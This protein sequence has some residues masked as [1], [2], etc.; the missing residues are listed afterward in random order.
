MPTLR[1]RPKIDRLFYILSTVT[2]LIVFVPMLVCGILEP[3]TLFI[4]V[5]I[6][7]FTAYFLVSPL[8]GYVE[9][10]SDELFIKYGFIMKRE[11]P[12]AK[13]RGIER[14]RSIIS[15]SIMSLKNA[16]EHVNIK[17]NT[18]DVTTVS[19]KDEDDFLAEL[20]ARCNGRLH[21]IE[22]R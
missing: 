1:Y 2:F 6:F 18:F 15:H 17:Y 22:K 12:Y 19:L 4:T 21:N 13:I 3:S 14:E 11:I 9:L 10:G 20:N 5:P 8:F 7:L 16:L